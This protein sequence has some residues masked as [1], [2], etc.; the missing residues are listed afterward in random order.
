YVVQR[1]VSVEELPVRLGWEGMRISSPI[2]RF[3]DVHIEPQR[4]GP[5]KRARRSR[6]PFGFSD[7]RASVY[8]L[9]VESASRTAFEA[10]C[11][12]TMAFLRRQS[13]LER[14]V[15]LPVRADEESP[16]SRKWRVVD[17]ALFHALY[18]GTVANMVPALTGFSFDMAKDS[19]R[20]A[21]WR[22]ETVL[23]GI[24]EERLLWNIAKKHG[25]KTL[26]GATG[27]NGL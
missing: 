12:K 27:C 25:Y 15:Q 19:E 20:R 13:R 16:N 24:P 11:P 9:I 2:H 8:I 14:P 23:E 1:A 22:C 6:L 3:G 18:G 26:F 5:R 17:L 10:F 7:R 4:L 21:G